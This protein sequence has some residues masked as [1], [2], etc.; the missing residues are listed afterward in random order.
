[1]VRIAIFALGSRGDIEPY[2]ALAQGLVRSGQTVRVVTNEDFTVLVKSYGLDVWPIDVSVEA[3]LRAKNAAAAMEGGGFFSAFRVLREHAERGARRLIEIGGEA[4]KDVDV[5]VTG[6]SGLFVASALSEKLGIP[7]VQAYNIPL[8]PTA[9]WAG[10][11]FP[12]MSFPPRSL[13]HQLSHRLTRLAVWQVSRSAGERA[14]K[15]MLGLGGTSPFGLSESPLTSARPVI[16]GFSE[17]VLPRP[18]D[19]DARTV[20]TGYWFANEPPGFTPDAALAR[21]LDDGEPPVYVGFGSMSSEQPEHTLRLVLDAVG[22]RRALIHAGWGGLSS[23]SLPKNVHGI[24]SV[25]HSWLFPRTAAV[26]HHGG[27]GT[28]GAAFRAGVPV[29]VVPFHGDQLFWAMRAEALG[30]G[31]A[32]LPRKSLTS[33]KLR[34]A[35]EGVLNDA[36]KRARARELGAAIAKE[37]GVARAVAVI[38]SG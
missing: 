4:A 23:S 36:A 9:A 38:V 5:I 15:E 26:V 35:I 18:P 27:A 24:A 8:T 21:F 34:D 10:A 32:P 7:L 17:A 19:W 29:V 37:D 22:S 16:Y 13:A 2:I 25:P 28:S 12:W 6:F 30:V 14:R 1:M 3:A 33:V 31:P 20:I 11:L